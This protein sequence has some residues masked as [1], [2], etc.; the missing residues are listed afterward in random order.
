[1]ILILVL[2]VWRGRPRP[3]PLT[4]EQWG[5]ASRPFCSGSNIVRTCPP[6][7][8]DCVGCQDLFGNTRAWTQGTAPFRSRGKGFLRPRINKIKVSRQVIFHAGAAPQ[9]VWGK[10]YYS[11]I[12][13]GAV[14]V[15]SR[16][17]TRRGW[18]VPPE[19]ELRQAVQAALHE[20]RRGQLGWKIRTLLTQP[21]GAD[22][23]ASFVMRRT[24]NYIQEE[25]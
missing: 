1:M 11:N 5:G 2:L 19:A 8:N 14:E 3:R 7:S 12:L 17:L 23:L 21:A 18:Y 15:A 4:Y 24:N 20:V 22:F 16:E 6:V 9:C 25:F 13:N 10:Q